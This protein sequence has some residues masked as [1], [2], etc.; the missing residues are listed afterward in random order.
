M[1]HFTDAQRAY[2]GTQRL[3]RLATVDPGGQPQNNPVGFF[4]QDDDTILVGG[5][6]MGAT[7]KWRNLQAN[8]RLSLVVD[9][10]VSVDPWKVRFVE[11]RGTAELLVGPHGLGSHFSPEVIRI[12]PRKVHSWGLEEE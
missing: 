4:L 2:L 3:A 5:L 1:T 7:K 10:V 11:I 8:P 9:D 12:H 6:R